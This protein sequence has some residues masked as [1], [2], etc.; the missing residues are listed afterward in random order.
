M[1]KPD[2]PIPTTNAEGLRLLWTKTFPAELARQLSILTPEKLI[3]RAAT[4]KWTSI[5]SG[6]V[7]DV[8]KITGIPREHLLPELFAPE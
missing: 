5:P 8:A 2:Y 7:N 4:A 6:R 3:S 1:K